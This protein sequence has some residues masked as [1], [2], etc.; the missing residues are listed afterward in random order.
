MESARPP[1]ATCRQAALT[2]S[3]DAVAVA[4]SFPSS[5]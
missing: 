4:G 5:T 3:S 1:V 2:H